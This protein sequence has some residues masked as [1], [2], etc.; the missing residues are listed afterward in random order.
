MLIDYVREHVSEADQRSAQEL[1]A[2]SPS[3]EEEYEG[4]IEAMQKRLDA[5]NAM[6]VRR[7]TVEHMLKMSACWAVPRAANVSARK[8][9]PSGDLPME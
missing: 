3:L 6:I 9:R 2:N 5:G 4:V 1:V 7:R 8:K